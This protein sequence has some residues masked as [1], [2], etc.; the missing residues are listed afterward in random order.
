MGAPASP[1]VCPMLQARGLQSRHRR[2][3][4][5]RHRTGRQHGSTGGRRRPAVSR[6]RTR[7]GALGR[8]GGVRGW[9]V[10]ASCME[11]LWVWHTCRW[12][13]YINK[14]CP[15]PT[16]LSCLRTVGD[17]I[18]KGTSFFWNTTSPQLPM[19][20]FVSFMLSLALILCVKC[21][22]WGKKV[23]NKAEDNGNNRTFGQR[24]GM[25]HTH[26]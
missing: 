22:R 24:N 12:R 4:L 20:Q 18:C 3:R 2:H 25:L 16:I 8:H 21:A 10:V 6:R 17:G 5:L 7:Q 14:V 9:V 19:S 13:I 15:L 26:T 11:C 1:T 23:T